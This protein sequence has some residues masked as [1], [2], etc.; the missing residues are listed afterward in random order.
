MEMTFADRKAFGDQHEAR[1]RQELERRGWS[2]AQYGQGILPGAICRAL[3][4]TESAFRFDPDFVV[5][6]GSDICLIDAKSSMRGENARA[7]TISRKSLRAGVRKVAEV[8]LPLYYVFHNL[9]VATPHEL[10]Q[11]SGVSSLGASGGYLSF[12]SHLPRPFDEVF[13]HSPISLAAA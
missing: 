13:G 11:F 3:A 6:R 10:M 2:V 5:A 9:G 7:Y 8:D 4:R 1:V 12:G